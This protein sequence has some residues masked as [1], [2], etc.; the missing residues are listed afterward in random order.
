MSKE[1][2]EDTRSTKTA[3][4]RIQIN[5]GVKE[6]KNLQAPSPLASPLAS[7]LG[8]NYYQNIHSI[9][10]SDTYYQA[11]GNGYWSSNNHNNNNRK[12]NHF[13]RIQRRSSLDYDKYLKGRSYQL[14]KS[15]IRSEKT[16]VIYRNY[17]W[18]LCDFLQ[19][20]TEEI[21]SRYGPTNNNYA[22]HEN[23]TDIQ[24][25]FKL[26]QKVED[27]LLLM[28]TRLSNNN[29]KRNSI[30]TLMPAVKFF[31]EMNDIIVNWKKISKLL[32]RHSTNAADQAYTREQIKKMLEHS[33]LRT[34]IPILFMASS[35]MRLGGFVGL[36][37]GCV[38]PIYEDDNNISGKILAA[39]VKVYNGEPEQ[40]DTFISPEA[41]KEYDEV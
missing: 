36:S 2:K 40:Y 4:N 27:Y 12:T 9:S 24:A 37:D 17:L 19:L 16:M 26:Q 6:I 41:W 14:F 15:A 13:T 22:N 5:N 31:C 28:Q 21:V 30:N 18:H 23:N 3:K 32:P 35:G 8:P 39:N 34:K 29:F 10:S 11:K 38:R 1:N 20:N 7:P 25:P 33:D